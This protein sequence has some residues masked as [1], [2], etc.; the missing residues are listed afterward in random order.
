MYMYNMLY[1]F[2]WKYKYSFF[3]LFCLIILNYIGID[4]NRGLNDININSN[5]VVLFVLL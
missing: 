1:V 5:F 4:L 3:C 2:L